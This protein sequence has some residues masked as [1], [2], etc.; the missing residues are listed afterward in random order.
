MRGLMAVAMLAGCV[1]DASPNF[2]AD[3]AAEVEEAGEE[4]VAPDG[5]AAAEEEDDAAAEDDAEPDAST[6]YPAEDL[7]DND[8]DAAAEADHGDALEAESEPPP[9]VDEDGDGALA[10]SVTCPTGT[11]LCDEDPYRTCPSS[12][13]VG[14]LECHDSE[15]N[16]C[17]GMTDCEDENCYFHCL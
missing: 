17:D 5:D 3:V 9:C 6:D 8:G 12:V 14:A 11:D 13:E 7:A 4:S 1:V 16:D 2:D 10:C 15:D